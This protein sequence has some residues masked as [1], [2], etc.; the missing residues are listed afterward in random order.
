MSQKKKK[1]RRYRARHSGTCN[2]VLEK[3]RQE[4]CHKFKTN[5]SYRMS[6]G[7]YPEY[8]VRT[9][10]KTNRKEEEGRKQKN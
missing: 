9:C 8:R 1:K 4:D 3:L 6:P 5:L 7:C 10:L 2:P